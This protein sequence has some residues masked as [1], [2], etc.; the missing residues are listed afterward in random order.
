MSVKTLR[1]LQ[2]GTYYHDDPLCGC[3]EV[4][5]LR[6]E[7]ATLREIADAARE[8]R[9]AEGARYKAL[10]K[11][12]MRAIEDL[13]DSS[14]DRDFDAETNEWSRSWPETKAYAEAV[15]VQGVKR[16]ALDAALRKG[17]R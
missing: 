7:V 5:K 10:D 12:E 17:G 8:Y 3:A 4:E 6:K 13:P 11:M 1:C 16:A 9:E 14:R 2:C 15:R